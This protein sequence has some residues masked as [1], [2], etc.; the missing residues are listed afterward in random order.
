MQDFFNA[1]EFLSKNIHLAGWV[2][3]MTVVARVSWKA[4]KFFDTIRDSGKTL[5]LLA[6]NHLPHLQASLDTLTEKVPEVQEGLTSLSED[7]KD[8]GT[9]IKDMRKDLLQFLFTIAKKD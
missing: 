5:H 1:F 9:E 7:V 3:V 8:V 2:F 4:S 6:T